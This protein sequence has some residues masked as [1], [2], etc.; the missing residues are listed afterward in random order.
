MAFNR[1]TIAATLLAVIGLAGRV[2]PHDGFTANGLHYKLEGRGPDVVLIHAFQMDLREWD[3]VA[4]GLA[5]SRRVVRYDVRGHGKSTIDGPLPSQAADLLA[6]LDELKL[7]QPT[8]VGLSMGATVALDFAVT[9]PDR[10]SRLILVSPGVPGIK[11]D[12]DFT[13]MSPILDA[14]RVGQPAKAAEAWWKSKLFDATRA[15]AADTDRVHDI[16]LDN[17]KIWSFAEP[18]PALNP[19]AVTRLNELAMSVVA[20]A[21]DRDPLGGLEYARAIATGVRNGRLVTVTGAGHML[22]LERP[23]ELSRLIAHAT[24]AV[25]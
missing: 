3:D 11:V 2:Q 6:L 18:P 17:A 15:R 24:E 7:P 19:P 12:V 20:I 9:H 1:P 13:W 8:L 14:V 5:G 4:A 25:K 23:D 16:V 22:T 21:G 10:V